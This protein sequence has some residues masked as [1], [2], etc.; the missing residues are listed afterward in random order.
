MRGDGVPPGIETVLAGLMTPTVR[1][2]QAYA[3]ARLI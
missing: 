3:T 2:C 1:A